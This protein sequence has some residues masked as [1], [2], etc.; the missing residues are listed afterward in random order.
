MELKPFYMGSTKK[1]PEIDFNNFTGELILSGKS[2]PENAINV[3]SK[4]FQWVNQYI[5]DPKTNTHLRLN[6]EYFNT[7]SS[8]WIT[9][10]VKALSSVKESGYTLIIHMYFNSEE[11]QDIDIEDLKDVLNM[12]VDIRNTPNINF[13]IKLYGKNNDGT[14]TTES[15]VYF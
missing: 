14:I 9:K 2:I 13:C 7:A 1:T 6:L 4:A 12:V 3:Y 8:I 10:I 15:D 11:L 5:L